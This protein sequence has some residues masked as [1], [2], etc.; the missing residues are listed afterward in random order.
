MITGV[1]QNILATY[2]GTNQSKTIGGGSYPFTV[3]I[4]GNNATLEQIY[5]KCQYLLRQATD[6]DSG[7]GTV[8]GKTATQL[9]YFV[10]DTLYTTQGVFI[11]NLQ[12]ADTNRIVFMDQNGVNRQYPYTAAGTISFNSNLVGAGSYYRMYFADAYGSASAITVNDAT[13]AAIAGTISSSPLPFTYDYDNNV[14]G[15]RTAGTDASVVVVAGR[16]GYAKP[17]VITGTLTKS[18][19]IALAATAETDRAYI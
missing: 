1:Y 12:N 10:G 11:T 5:T 8:I 17:V 6:I 4:D 18:K 3:V 2:Y 19:S 14:Q 7:T 15:G 16:P 9:C 13:A